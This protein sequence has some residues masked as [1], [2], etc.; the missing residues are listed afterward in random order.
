MA[1][2]LKFMSECTEYANMKPKIQKISG[3][4][5]QPLS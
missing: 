1:H 2:H 4:V 5:A 3:E